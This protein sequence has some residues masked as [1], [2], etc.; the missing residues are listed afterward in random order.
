[1]P[2][3]NTTIYF[4]AGMY[5][6]QHQQSDN[7]TF[8]LV[9]AGSADPRPYLTKSPNGLQLTSHHASL[10]ALS[11]DRSEAVLVDP[12][13]GGVAPSPKRVKL[14]QEHRDLIEQAIRD[15]YFFR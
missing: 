1:M 3:T 6:N 13:H 7:L 9:H 2:D 11:E 15:D 10:Y 8:K 14:S 5:C 4:A 12:R